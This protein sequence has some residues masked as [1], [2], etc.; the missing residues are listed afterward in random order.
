MSTGSEPSL[1]SLGLTPF[2]PHLPLPSIVAEWA[3]IIPLVCHLA[4]QRD[5]YIT[6]G[7]IALLGR[8]SVGIFPRLGTLSGLARLM[9]RGTKYLDHA[10]AR[11]GSSRTVWD[12]KWGS[13]FPCANGAVCSAIS[14]YLQNRARVPP[15]RMPEILSPK[16]QSTAC[17]K[18]TPQI[19]VTAK[20]TN[21]PSGGELC[22]NKSTE[23]HAKDEGIR[24]Y[25]TLHVYRLFRT[26]ERRSL[27]D[28]VGRLVL[29]IPGR[30]TWFL[31]LISLAVVFGL[32]GSY[33]SAALVVCTSVSELVALG[34]TIRRPPTYLRN[35]ENHD[36]C[37]LVAPHENATEWHLYVGDRAVADTLLNKPMFVLPE[38]KSASFAA[39][40][41]WFANLLQFAAMTFVAAQK[42]WDG[43]WMV[44]LLAIHWVL[45]YF[46]YGGTL[47]RDWLEREGIEAQVGSFEFTG[48]FAMMG[49]IQVFSESARTR[50]MDDIL[51]PHPRRELWLKSLRG[52]KPIDELDSHDS[53]WLESASEASLAAADVLKRTFNAHCS[54]KAPV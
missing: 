25:Q 32:L 29:S 4:T 11:G 1:G 18:P 46:L 21:S 44:V 14:K 41:F 8:L 37:M 2:I 22:N 6:I 7:D 26:Q 35:N 33:G 38:G 28:R 17:Q 12:V 23:G 27:K 40:W 49:A 5:D 42:G 52:E 24:R 51:T 13:V 54:Y 15:Q 16:P 39:T 19:G 9:E 53:R 47:A 30:I 31:L 36:A 34:I 10:S 45:R 43:V 50:W 48:R 20:P 3:A